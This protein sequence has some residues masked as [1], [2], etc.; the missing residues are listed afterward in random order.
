MEGRRAGRQAG[1]IAYPSARVEQP[2]QFAGRTEIFDAGHAPS[3]PVGCTLVTRLR[4]AVF[5]DRDGVLT[6]ATVADGVPRP[7]RGEAPLRLRPGVEAVCRELR[8]ADLLLVCVTNQ[9]DIARGVISE[10]SVVAA[11]ADLQARLGLDAVIVCPHDDAN[12]C[13]CRK[14]HP[15]ML[16]RAAEAYGID[17]KRSVMVGD[18]WRDIEAGR[19]AG[20]TTLFVDNRYD[21]R[22]P[23]HPD[24]TTTR[25][26]GMVHEII[27]ATMTND[28][29]G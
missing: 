28:L 9:P 17:L 5:F 27:R 6:E 26:D 16:L 22:K 4:P 25:L 3:R 7:E 23:E 21:E 29:I 19:K 14:P 1:H 24:L 11:N 10:A 13:E 12:S 2:A 8:E 15:G 20:C 18:R